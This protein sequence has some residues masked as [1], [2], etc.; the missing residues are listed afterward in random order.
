MVSTRQQAYSKKTMETQMEGLPRSVAVQVSSC[1]Q[2][3]SLLLP[4]EGS[5]DSTCVRCEQVDELLSLVVELKEEL[6]RLRTIRVR[7]QETEWWSDSLAC[8]REGCQGH[9]PRKVA[10]PLPCHSRTGLTDEEGWKRVL[11]WH[12]EN[13]PCLPSSLPQ[14]PLSNRF[15]MLKIEEEVTGEAREDLPRREPKARRSSPHLETSCQE[16]KKGGHGGRLPSQ[17]NRGPHLQT[18]PE[19]SG[20]VLPFQGL[21][22]GHNQAQRSL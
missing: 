15:E 6:H 17:R 19:A 13:P 16:R 5:R 9:T 14:L 20:S 22:Q 2:C 12:H 3:L 11:T 18:R 8:Q 7:E 10:D 21:R 4:R 1:W